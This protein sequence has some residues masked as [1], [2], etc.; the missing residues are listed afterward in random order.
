MSF[1]VVETG[2]VDAAWNLAAEQY[3]FDSFPG[4]RDYLILWQN[5]RA[6][7]IG[8]YQNTAAEI[9]EDY[10]RRKN[11]QVVRRL[12]GGGAVYHDLGNL[13][14]TVIADT[15]AGSRIDLALFCGPL[16]RT[17][18]GFGVQ[19][20]ISGRNDVTVDGKKVS[21]NAQYRKNGRVMHHGT[22]L[23]DSDLAA[24][25]S[26]LHADAEK[27][28]G[29]GVDSVRSR[30]TDLK[31]YLP[32]GIGMGRFKKAF[33]KELSRDEG[34]ERLVL[35]EADR[36]AVS[37]LADER[38]RRREWNYGASPACT[39]LKKRRIEGCGTVELYITLEKDR[40]AALS[41]RGDFFGGDGLD[42]LEKA[43]T[44]LSPERRICEEALKPLPV[45]EII[46]GL[47]KE[48]FLTLLCG[49]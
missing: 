48:A 17:L 14:Y 35:S 5:R 19:A 49:E 27:L 46:H 11:I 8:K 39:L 24:V 37:R 32:K 20:E 9:N 23:F 47:S 29:K 3:I 36:A 30:V 41:V 1:A 7:I 10:V 4:D 38:Y 43:L 26:A 16:V 42:S 40:I 6:V 2:S 25:S 18:A 44:G 13:N 15:A 28:S 31:P 22:V 33:L 21:G 45:E 12:S 34:F